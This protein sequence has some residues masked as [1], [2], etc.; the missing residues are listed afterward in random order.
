M[1]FGKINKIFFQLNYSAMPPT[2]TA[3]TKID[4]PDIEAIEPGPF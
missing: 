1:V 4:W 3:N 2:T